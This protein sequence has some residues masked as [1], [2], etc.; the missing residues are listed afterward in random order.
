MSMINVWFSRLFLLKRSYYGGHIFQIIDS[1]RF[2]LVSCDIPVQN[3]LFS[4]S[5]CILT[6]WPGSCVGVS[7]FVVRRIHSRFSS[8]FVVLD[9][10]LFG[11]P[12]WVLVSAVVAVLCDK[13]Y[14]FFKLRVFSRMS[15]SR[16]FLSVILV[17]NFDMSRSSYSMSL[18][19]HVF[20]SVIIFFQCSKG[21]SFSS[22]FA[23]KKD[24]IV[25]GSVLN[26][27]F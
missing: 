16:S 22:S 9:T 20:S 26:S 17:M 11:F 8:V 27:A 3:S 18:V 12:G 13:C 21:V 2:F 1:F 5:C 7:S 4:G 14:V 25:S 19:S 15:F 10:V 24:L 23:Q 6:F